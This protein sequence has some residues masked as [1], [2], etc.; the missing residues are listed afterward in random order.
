MARPPIQRDPRTGV[1]A[2]SSHALVRAAMNDPATFASRA[3][4]V[5]ADADAATLHEL[6][7]Q[8][9]PFV[10]TLADADPPDHTRFRALVD[11]EFAPAR[12][13]SLVP[14]LEK[15]CHALVD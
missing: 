2:V 9:V 8:T 5:L 10:A 15:R 3:E 12:V 11:G 14:E 1:F 6:A 4:P 13:A 7:K